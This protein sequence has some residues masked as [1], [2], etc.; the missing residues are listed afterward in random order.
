MN[1]RLSTDNVTLYWRLNGEILSLQPWGADGVRARATNLREFPEI[2]GALLDPPPAPGATAT[3]AEG[4]GILTNGKLR[5]EIWPDGTLHFFNTH[6]GRA[7]LEEPKPVFNRPPAR[8][9]RP[10]GS[11]LSRVEASFRARPGETI[12]G[13]GQPAWPA[14]QQGLRHRPGAAEHGSQHPILCFEPG[15]RLSVEQP[16]R[17][18]S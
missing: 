15:L 13:L 12:F 5:A 10:Q 8:W 16:R 2:P 4:K 14:G 9:Y 3:L 17:R 11:D 7:L 18:A 6:T 1:P